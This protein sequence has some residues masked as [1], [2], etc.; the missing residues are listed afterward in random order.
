MTGFIIDAGD[1]T[2][3]F[4]NR[5]RGKFRHFIQLDIFIGVNIY[6]KIYFRRLYI[7]SFFYFLFFYFILFLLTINLKLIIV[8]VEIKI[9]NKEAETKRSALLHAQRQLCMVAVPLNK[10]M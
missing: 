9:V 4:Y 8:H 2:S 1:Y 3:K 7:Y 10:A 5:E 6:G